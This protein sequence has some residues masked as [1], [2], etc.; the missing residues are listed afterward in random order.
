MLLT[1][2]KHTEEKTDTYPIHVEGFLVNSDIVIGNF[3]FSPMDPYTYT[4]QILVSNLMSAKKLYTDQA[5]ET[6]KKSIFPQIISSLE[7]FSSF[8]SFCSSIYYI[9]M[10]LL[11][12]LYEN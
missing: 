4:L 8:N 2:G 10:K 5:T 1:A 12:Q 11:R 7:L 6:E 3:W 9:K